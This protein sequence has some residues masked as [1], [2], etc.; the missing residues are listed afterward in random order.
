MGVPSASPVPSEGPRVPSGQLPA[1]MRQAHGGQP[2]GG[3][4][5]GSRCVWGGG[6]PPGAPRLL[7][8]ERLYPPTQALA[9]VVCEVPGAH[10]ALPAA[11]SPTGAPSRGEACHPASRSWARPPQARRF[12][13]TSLHVWG[14]SSPSPRHGVSVHLRTRNLPGLPHDP[15]KAGGPRAPWR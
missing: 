5:E 15:P 3:S 13:E 12:P 8:A 2:A 6:Q 7:P 11:A 14:A 1:E 4:P 9:P 10:D